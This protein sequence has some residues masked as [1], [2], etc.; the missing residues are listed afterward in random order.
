MAMSMVVMPR[1]IQEMVSVV[2]KLHVL[3]ETAGH[4]IFKNVALPTLTANDR[5]RASPLPM[6][7]AR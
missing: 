4:R 6:C 7:D 2:T 5:D 1:F 3:G